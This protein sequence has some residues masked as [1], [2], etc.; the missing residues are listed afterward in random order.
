MVAPLGFEPMGEIVDP[1]L[2][3][4]VDERRG[5]IDV[6]Q[7]DQGIDGAVAQGHGWPAPA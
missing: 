7:L 3:L 5:R 6:D 4:G 2:D 1:A